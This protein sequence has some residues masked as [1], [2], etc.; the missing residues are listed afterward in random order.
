MSPT[1]A[2]TRVILRH[3]VEKDVRDA[4]SVVV[5]AFVITV[6]VT[7]VVSAFV[8]VSI[9]GW[10]M[11]TQLTRWYA[12]GAGVYLTAVYLPLYI[13]HGHTRR[14]FLTQLPG[15]IVAMVVTLGALVAVGYLVEHVVYRAA[16]WEQ[17]L[18]QDH[19]FNSTTEVGLVFA[20]F[21]LLLLVYL[22]GGALAGAAFYRHAALGTVLIPVLLA[23]AG[24]SEAVTGSVQIPFVVEWAARFGLTLDPATLT[25]AALVST[26][27][28]VLLG[29]ATW[30]IAKDV[31]VRSPS[32]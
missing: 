29:L 2:S 28:V 26:V 18:T 32:T 20:E 3:R 16:G 19:L 25:S 27:S 31:P 14:A 15:S 30:A 24:V 10:D 11:A 13:A 12:G 17:G 4:A 1:L 21:S 9:S 7:L 6:V 8:D 22:V 5:A 23:A